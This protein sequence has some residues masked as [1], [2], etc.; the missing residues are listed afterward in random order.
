M[1]NRLSLRLLVLLV[2]PLMLFSCATV[3]SGPDQE[4]TFRSQPEGAKVKVMS[5]SRD[6]QYVVETPRT[7]R[8]SRKRNYVATFELSGYHTQTF[9]VSGEFGDAMAGSLVGNLILGGGI[10]LII[11]GSTGSNKSL[12][13]VVEVVLT[14]NEDPKPLNAFTSKEAFQRIDAEVEKREARASEIEA[15]NKSHAGPDR[16]VPRNTG[17]SS[18][19]V[20]LI[21][22]CIEK[23][24]PPAKC[25]NPKRDHLACRRK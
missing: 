6:K 22:Q 12:P 16:N 21:F 20:C 10:G 1:K 25:R 4:I 17:P 18:I 23:E 9:P 8:L 2:F 7:L 14:K 5:F 24:K 11:D 15:W 19:D 3:L 13:E